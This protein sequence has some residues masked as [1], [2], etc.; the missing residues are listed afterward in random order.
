MMSTKAHSQAAEQLSLLG[1]DTSVAFSTQIEILKA[2]KNGIIG[3]KTKKD[4]YVSL[5]I[6]PK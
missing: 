5:D 6:I 4:L 2:I 3:N 1:Q